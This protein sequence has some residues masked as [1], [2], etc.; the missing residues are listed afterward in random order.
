MMKFFS[1]VSY[2]EGDVVIDSGSP[3]SVV[4]ET[5]PEAPI[6]DTTAVDIPEQAAYLGSKEVNPKQRKLKVMDFSAFSSKQELDDFIRQAGEDAFVPEEEKVK[7]VKEEKTDEE[8]PSDKEDTKAFLDNIGI[9]EEEFKTLPEKIQEKLANDF[10]STTEKGTEYAE[11][12]DRYNKLAEDI[13][14]LEKD[15]VIAARLEEKLSGK[16][17]VA[18]ELPPITNKEMKTLLQFA[19]DPEAFEEAV[20]ELIVAKADDVLKIERG[21]VERRA[22]QVANENKALEVLQKMISLE[23]RIGIKEKDLSKIDKN[24]PEYSKLFGEG[25]LMKMMEAKRYSP[26]QIAT[27]G[28]EELLMEFAASK[29][30]NKERD[31]KLVKSGAQKL[32]DNIRKAKQSAVVIPTAKKAP[33]SMSVTGD[34]YDIESIISEIAGGSLKTWQ[35]LSDEADASGNFS[36]L[37]ELSAIFEKGM[38]ARNK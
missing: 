33:D 14:E 28:A 5:T 9:T 6:P 38:R 25:G 17:Y 32:I 20:N 10:T 22:T 16:Q 23:P 24:H 18:R 2:A 12:Q 3:E 36:R 34:S 7:K 19:G 13:K 4:T 37:K 29:G 26:L 11:L 1:I 35:K 31:N 8:K 21:V 30:W 15:A 27:K